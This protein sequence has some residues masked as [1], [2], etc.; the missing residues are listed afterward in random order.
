MAAASPFL[1]PHNRTRRPYLPVPDEVVARFR[2]RVE[3]ECPDLL[4]QG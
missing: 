2:Q 1:A 3:E 4:W